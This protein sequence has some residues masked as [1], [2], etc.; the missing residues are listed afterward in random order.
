MPLFCKRFIK[1][2]SQPTCL[3]DQPFPLQVSS[4]PPPPFISNIHFWNA[5]TAGKAAIC[6]PSLITLEL[7]IPLTHL[8]GLFRFTVTMLLWIW[9]HRSKGS[10]LVSLKDI[11]DFGWIINISF[12]LAFN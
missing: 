3:Y 8:R 10:R 11:G 1:S 12:P 9:N 6:Y 7:V 2:P 4:L 5:D